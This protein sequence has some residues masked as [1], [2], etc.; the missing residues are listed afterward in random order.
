MK[1]VTVA[2]ERVGCINVVYMFPVGACPH[3]SKTFLSLFQRTGHVIYSPLDVTVIGPFKAKYGV[4]LN[5]RIIVNPGGRGDGTH[6]ATST[7]ASVYPISLT[8]N[9]FW[10]AFEN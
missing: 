7:S 3:F 1:F 6:D 8:I 4:A 2:N 9:N 10:A 5:D